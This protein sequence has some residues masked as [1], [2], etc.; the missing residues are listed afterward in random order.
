MV[1]WNAESKYYHAHSKP[2][3]T[4]ESR[5]HKDVPIQFKGIFAREKVTVSSYPEEIFAHVYEN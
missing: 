5:F 2:K 3:K 4:R 1:V